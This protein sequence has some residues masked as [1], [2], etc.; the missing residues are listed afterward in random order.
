MDQFLENPLDQCGLP[1]AF[2]C[3]VKHRPVV[4]CS[5]RSAARRAFL[6]RQSPACLSFR[7]DDIDNPNQE[8]SSGPRK[9]S[10][11]AMQ[12]RAAFKPRVTLLHPPFRCSRAGGDE[13]PAAPAARCAPRGYF[14]WRARMASISSMTRFISRMA[15]SNGAEVVGST[16]AALSRSTGYLE[17]PALSMAR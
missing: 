11:A 14:F 7:F 13:A 15:A 8:T 12:R 3:P 1:A 4:G 5:A 17:P 2:A 6:S 9:V 10:R 16:P